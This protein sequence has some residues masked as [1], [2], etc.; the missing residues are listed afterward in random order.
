MNIKNGL[1]FRNRKRQKYSCAGSPQNI[2]LS[3][4]VGLLITSLGSYSAVKQSILVPS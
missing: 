1:L 3:K 4:Y 2:L